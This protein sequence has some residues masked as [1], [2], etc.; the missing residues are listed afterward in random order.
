MST[1]INFEEWMASHPEKY[2]ERTRLNYVGGLRNAGSWFDITLEK[3][4]LEITTTEEFQKALKTIKDLPD[5]AYINGEVHHHT[6]SA[7]ASAY[8]QYLSASK[9]FTWVAFYSE[10]ADK[11]LTYK[12]DRKTIIDKIVAVYDEIDIKLPKLES[13]GLPTDMDPFTVFGLFNKGITE[14]NRIAIAKGLAKA[15][16]VK[17]EVP[18]EY[19]GVPVVNNLKATFYYFKGDRKEGD[20]DNLWAVFES[21]LS[22]ADEGS[23]ESKKTFIECFDAV[24]S[25]SGIR[26]NITMALFWI[27]PYAFISLD[28]RNREFLKDKNYMPESFVETVP[29]FNNVPSDAYVELCDNCKNTM[30]ENDL[31]F[32]NFPELS[33]YAWSVTQNSES[34]DDTIKANGAMGDADVRKTHYWLYAPGEGAS[35]W[36][37]F[38]KRGIMAIAWAAIGDLSEYESKEAMKLAMKEAYDDSR[39]YKMSAHATWQFANEIQVGDVV[40]VKR[41]RDTIIGRGIV[42]GKYRFDENAPDAYKNIHDVNWTHSGEWEHP[43][44]AA[45]K[46]LTDIT[47]YTDYV[48]KLCA[49]FE[50]DSEDIEA[51]EKT[52]P[53]YSVEDFLS[54]VYMTGED[55]DTLVGVLENK[56]NI[57]LQGAPGVGKTFAAKRLAYSMIGE[58][59]PERVQMVQFHQS[60]S[61]EDFIEGYRPA[62]KNVDGADFIIKKG[63]FYKFCKKAADDDENDYF[64]IIDEINRG[65]LSKIFG[66]LFMLIETDKRGVELQLLYSDE[67]FFVPKNVYIIGMMNTAD[68]SLAMLDYALRRRFS[69]VEMK[70][71]FETEGFM[72]YQEGLENDKFNSL[73]SCV[74]QLNVRISDDDTLGEGFCIGHSYF[75]NLDPNKLDERA[76]KAIVEFEL[77]PLLKEYWFDESDKV[78]EW[79]TKLRSAIK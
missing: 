34:D 15:F 66:E 28:S 54:E 38:Y 69:F 79:K 33:A 29:K 76:L 71:G 9:D 3:P 8:Q 30:Q 22:Y 14:K 40:F 64:F 77:I 13:D 11:L 44:K 47:S 16:D 49:L 58:K 24:L 17:A 26:W 27:R 2:S 57:I 60:Y 53:K 50:D 78:D 19:P 51:E 48:E 61:Y 73:I 7:A 23:E 74:K 43:G 67:K 55:Y 41:G 25:Q 75:C 12:N 6:F 65:N 72:A 52:Y 10:L 21:A 18:T 42:T 63:S 62:S 70:P 45:L 5:Y 68:R 37:N 4:L 56:K 1:V 31:P 46:T 35:M 36:E 39:P 32:E 59:N 20:I